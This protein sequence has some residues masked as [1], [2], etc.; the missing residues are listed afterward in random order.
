MCV[1]FL[2]DAEGVI[3]GEVNEPFAGDDFYVANDYDLQP[4]AVDP[5]SHR[6]LRIAEYSFHSPG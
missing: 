2:G 3:A 1:A 6:L 5:T 4:T